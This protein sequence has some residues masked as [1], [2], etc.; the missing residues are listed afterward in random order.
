[1][2]NLFSV[3]EL[4]TLCHQNV[5]H[6]HLD[7]PVREQTKKWGVALTRTT[8][9]V[10]DSR[11]VNAGFSLRIKI[12]PF[13]NFSPVARVFRAKYSDVKRR[14]PKSIYSFMKRRNK[15]RVNFPIKQTPHVVKEVQIF[16][17]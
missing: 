15:K 1:M 8:F 9:C 12:G 11:S 16:C 10:K 4:I 7:H 17:I 14:P 13:G 3:V 5:V 2:W 6:D